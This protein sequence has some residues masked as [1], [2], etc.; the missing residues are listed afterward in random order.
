MA[1]FRA[2]ALMTILVGAGHATVTA[3]ETPLPLPIAVFDYANVPAQWLSWAEAEMARI[4]R[5]IGVAI[6]WLD[7]RADNAVPPGALI[8]VIRPGLQS[9]EP[10]T[11]QDVIG[12]SVGTADEGGRVAYVL[13]GRMDQFR[14]EQSPAIYRAKLLGH[15]MAHE[16]GHLLLPNQSHSRTGLMRGRW[17]RADVELAQQGRLQFTADQARLIRSKILRLSENRPEVQAR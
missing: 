1:A 3:A 9:T 11:P 4:Y 17:S 8:V 16:I 6:T 15:F 10:T 14:L 12:F 5:D 7:L 2:L 13:Y